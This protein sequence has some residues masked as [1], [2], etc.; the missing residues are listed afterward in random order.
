M[1]ISLTTNGFV[2]ELKVKSIRLVTLNKVLAINEC[3]KCEILTMNE[4]E[5]SLPN[6]QYREQTRTLSLCWMNVP[7]LGIGQGQEYLSILAGELLR[8]EVLAIRCACLGKN[9]VPINTMGI[10]CESCQRC[11]MSLKVVINGL[12]LS[13]DK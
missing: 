8:V 9:T 1:L 6:N 10:G 7:E 4:V 12:T 11:S 13:D 3:R 2:Q 5:Y